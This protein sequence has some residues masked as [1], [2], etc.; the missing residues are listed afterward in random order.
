MDSKISQVVKEIK[1]DINKVMPVF[2]RIIQNQEEHIVLDDGVRTKVDVNCKRVKKIFDE[3]IDKIKDSETSP[4]YLL[5]MMEFKSNIEKLLLMTRP[6]DYLINLIELSGDVSRLLFLTDLSVV[7]NTMILVGANGSGKSSFVNSLN[8]SSLQNLT[9][10][11]AQKNLY[12]SLNAY[13]RSDVSALDYRKVYQKSTNDDYKQDDIAESDAIKRIFEPFTFLITSLIND[14]TQ[15]AVNANDGVEDSQQYSLW[16]R[17]ATIWNMLIPEITFKVDALHRVPEVIKNGNKYSVNGLSDGEKCILYYIGNVLLAGENGYIIVDEPETFLNP[18]I[19]NRLWDILIKERSD[20]QFVFASHNTNFIN[21]RSNVTIVWCK[22]FN[23]PNQV[24]LQPLDLAGTLPQS[25]L[26]EL[27]GSRKKILFCEGQS[28]SN[29][30][31]RVYD[32]QVYSALYGDQYTVIPVGGHDKVIKYTTAFN[33]LPNFVEN[34]A[35]GIIDGDGVWD[36]RKE[37]LKERGIFVLP[38]NEI[39]MMLL[40]ESV[41]NSVLNLVNT[42]RQTQDLINEFKSKLFNYMSANLDKVVFQL[43]K[44]RV[45]FLLQSEF[46][47]SN[48]NPTIQSLIDEVAN[49]PKTIDTSSIAKNFKVKINNAVKSKDYEKILSLCNLKEEILG[50]IAKP[51]FRLDYAMF[52]VGQIRRNR[53]LQDKLRAKIFP[54]I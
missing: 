28:E 29:G 38:Y 4:T 15:K 45:D 14:H 5:T 39:E 20:C 41:M 21:A 34:S 2:E 26:T 27:V 47:N 37:N 40:D 23:P 49:M 32:Y 24:V 31:K 1:E 44:E 9:V 17:V 25:V 51:L 10:I 46:I 43:T 7:K 6:T 36:D 18:A 35:V 13:G 30:V 53:E 33:E 52:A 42:N 11:P 19:Y 22:Q 3:I 48:E 16:E 12:F 54:I 50:G 8:G